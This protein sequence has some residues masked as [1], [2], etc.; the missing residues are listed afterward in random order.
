MRKVKLS[1]FLSLLLVGC[2]VGSDDPEFQ[3]STGYQDTDD[4]GDESDT[5]DTNGGTTSWSGGW[6]GGDGDGDGDGDDDGILPDPDL[7][8]PGEIDSQL[9]E[10]VDFLFV[11]DNSGSMQDEQEN[12]INNFEVLVDGVTST[13]PTLQSFHLGVVTTDDYSGNADG[14][15]SLGSLVTQTHYGVCN[16]FVDGK[17]F[18]TEND[19]DVG[20]SFECVANL[21]ISGSGSERPLL[22]A[23]TALEVWPNQP[24]QCNEDFFRPNDALLVIVFIT[25]EDAP[26]EPTNAY[27]H[28]AWLKG[29]P[30]EVV[31]LSLVRTDE[32]GAYAPSANLINFTNMF[33]YGFI[34]DVCAPDYGPFMY[35]AVG[36]IGTACGF[37]PPS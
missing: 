24:G 23:E 12:L 22:A 18:I 16:P 29:D 14:C 6:T 33:Y 34:G 37:P 13:V 21:G 19:P 2:S 5:G 35:E 11:I 15:K 25:D 36:W 10:N 28:I 9:C 8:D 31:V 30:N 4:P 27:N 20:G 3:L 26:S 32:C 7:P 17:R 1:L